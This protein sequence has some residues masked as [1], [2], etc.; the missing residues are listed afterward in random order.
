[1]V[2]TAATRLSAAPQR[3]L[4]GAGV[5]L[6]CGLALA[7]VLGLGIFAFAG[8]DA[9]SG[10]RLGSDGPRQLLNTVALVLLVEWSV[11]AL[12]HDADSE[13]TGECAAASGLRSR[14][15]SAAGDGW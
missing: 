15:S 11:V 6:L 13:G 3:G 12:C 14:W 1:M 10:L 7:P 9:F 5:L 2:S 8:P 4:L